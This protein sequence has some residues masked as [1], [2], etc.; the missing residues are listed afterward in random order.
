MAVATGW[1]YWV[2]H[3]EETDYQNQLATRR[4]EGFS[5]IGF[6][7][8]SSLYSYLPKLMESL[9]IFGNSMVLGSI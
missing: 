8:I 5:V 6:N 2:R 9:I 7:N 3:V 1:G 4:R